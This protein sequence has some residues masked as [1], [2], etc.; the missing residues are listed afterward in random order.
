VE[1]RVANHP[2]TFETLFD[3]LGKDDETGDI[4]ATLSLGLGFSW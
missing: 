4:I 1:S 3:Y 2:L